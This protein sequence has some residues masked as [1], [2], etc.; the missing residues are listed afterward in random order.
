MG[1][2]RAK[3]GAGAAAVAV[4]GFIAYSAGAFAALFSSNYL[5]HRYC[6]LVQPWLVWTNVSTD[7]LIG[8]SYGVLFGC[9]SWIVISLRRV[10]GT[11]K[12]LWIFASF[13]LFIMAC[14]V[15]HVMEVV[16]VWWPMYPLSAAFKVLCAAI[17]VPTAIYFAK[18]TPA[19][20]GV[21]AK[22]I[23]TLDLTL[24]ER[25]AALFE[26][27]AAK[28]LLDHPDYAIFLLDPNGLISTWNLGA[29]RIKGYAASEVLGQH[30]SIFFPEEVKLALPVEEL[31]IAAREGRYEGEGW[32]VRKD[33][34]KFWGHLVLTTLRREDGSVAG[35]TKVTQDLSKKREIDAAL[36]QSNER[37]ARVAAELAVAN[38]HLNNLLDA[39][40][41][42]SM[43]ATDQQGII[44]TFNRGA[45]VMLGYMAEEVIGKHSPTL[46]HVE[47]EVEE[48]GTEL[49]EQLGRP[50]RGFN[51][52]V[53]SIGREN[54]DHAEWIYVH[55]DG[56]RL[57]VNLALSVIT[58][59]DGMPIGYLGV[60]ED[61]TERRM[62]ATKLAAA[63]WA[64][65]SVLESTS[66]SVVT[67]SQDWTM[68]YGNRHARKSLPDWVIGDNYWKAF[69]T[70]AASPTG[71]TL[72]KCMEQ[73]VEV[74][75]EIYYEP[76]K[77]WFR[78]R[79][80]PVEE[81]ISVFFSDISEEKEMQEQLEHEQVLREK[82]IEALSH[83]A[84][85]LA[86]E[87][88]NPLA[89]IHGRATDLRDLSE[90]A[91]TVAS[92]EV[93]RACDSIVKTTSRATNILRG[94]RGF[95]R[96]AK[97]DPMEWASVSEIVDGCFELQEARFARH[98]VE[99]RLDIPVHVPLLLCR[100]TQVGQIVTNLLNNA[101]D[102]IVQA[103]AV[104][105]WVSIS[106]KPV[107][108]GLEIAVT[109]SGPGI[110]DHLKKHL[111]EPFFTTKEV[112]LGM[113][114]GL[115]LS[116]AIAQDHGGS[117]ILCSESERTRFEL[118]LPIDAGDAVTERGATA[119]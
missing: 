108:D 90:R 42:V 106:V 14:G 67:I 27:N 85:G 74:R 9:L 15:T 57:I 48:R 97:N 70:L 103:H 8:I 117:L 115:S 114:V 89:I 60:A 4:M 99:M 56:H 44:T 111:M 53:S 3:V 18:V 93:Q 72:R 76:Y 86:H 107:A 94:L 91:E 46:F 52:F 102:A 118:Y 50:V 26:L 105:R 61:V 1:L 110:E 19:L 30:F 64:V 98:E 71:E 2:S 55:K 81:G 83:M 24:R 116:R 100:E 25:D 28:M 32:R 40:L 92:V 54:R 69:P 10:S 78:A 35:F 36:A 23:E 22:H 59:D 17:S 5:P 73:R 88:S 62:S 16:T 58:G 43:I 104:E 38:A 96:E 37:N 51:V 101:F 7:A 33:G 29:E 68:V 6:Y 11:K 87:I 47:A 31:E 75:Y 95:A 66:D 113:G 82:R 109:D 80:F 49:S 77:V 45:E 63:Y 79:G 65:N 34:T 84:G 119:A 41:F 112:G 39:S 13:G 12:Y 21:L 20:E